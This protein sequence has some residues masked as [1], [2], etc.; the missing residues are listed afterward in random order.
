MKIPRR[1][2][3]DEPAPWWWPLNTRDGQSATIKC[4]HCN[5]VATLTDHTIDANGK[6]HPSLAC[7]TPSCPFHEFIRLEGWP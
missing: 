6:V 2:A 7:P 5:I 4:P 1:Q 3:Q